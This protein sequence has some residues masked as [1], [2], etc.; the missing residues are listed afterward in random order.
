M[1][2][3]IDFVIKKYGN[4]RL[5]FGAGASIGGNIL[6]LL[7]GNQG[8]NCKLTAAFTAVNPIK[9]TGDGFKETLFGIYDK[10]IGQN[11]N[12]LLKRH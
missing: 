1:A 4:D 10:S 2:Q 3:V 7:L 9:F 11:F 5:L 6:N 12:R 8:L